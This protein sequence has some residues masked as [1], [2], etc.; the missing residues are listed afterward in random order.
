M[1]ALKCFLSLFCRLPA[2]RSPI[3]KDSSLQI[4]SNLDLIS[5]QLKIIRLKQ[6]TMESEIDG[7][8]PKPIFDQI[9]AFDHQTC[10]EIVQ[11]AT[12][13]GV[14]WSENTPNLFNFRQKMIKF[15]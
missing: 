7:Q 12:T 5:L 1:T 13:G 14:N 11:I 10:S 6:A 8:N 3:R 9:L 15:W 4:W 2:L